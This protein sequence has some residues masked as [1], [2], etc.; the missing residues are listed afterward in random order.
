[1]GS[2]SP[3]RSR[4]QGSSLSPTTKLPQSI[5]SRGRDSISNPPH[6]NLRITTRVYSSVSFPFFSSPVLLHS[7]SG[8]GSRFTIGAAAS[9]FITVGFLRSALHSRH[10]EGR[11]L[12]APSP[13]SRLGLTHGFRA[14]P[15]ANYC[16]GT[17][18]HI[19]KMMRQIAGRRALSM[20]PRKTAAAVSSGEQVAVHKVRFQPRGDHFKYVCHYIVFLSFCCM[21]C[22]RL[23]SC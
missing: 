17:L 22:Y 3:I 13:A 9:P 11:G 6:P 5:G 2:L 16:P 10:D 14:R 23:H 15:C 19:V 18:K 7:F 12:C 1:M 8:P 20:W 4:G 21:S